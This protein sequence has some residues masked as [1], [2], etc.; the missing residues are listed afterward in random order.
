MKNAHNTTMTAT[1]SLTITG[2][3]LKDN[4]PTTFS[5]H[6][7]FTPSL[8]HGTDNVNSRTKGTVTQR[9]RSPVWFKHIPDRFLTYSW[10]IPEIFLT[11]HEQGLGRARW[12][13]SVLFIT[14][15]SIHQIPIIYLHAA[16]IICWED[17]CSYLQHRY[18]HNINCMLFKNM[19]LL[20]QQLTTQ[21]YTQH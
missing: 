21:M 17:S 4:L 13:Y 14:K 20:Q 12:L 19:S 3:Y 10:H 1:T 16:I 8:C 18:T 11:E 7:A 6:V 2:L 5:I 9:I 15:S